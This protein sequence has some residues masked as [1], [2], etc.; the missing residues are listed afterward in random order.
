MNFISKEDFEG[1]NL[2]EFLSFRINITPVIIKIVYLLGVIGIVFFSLYSMF[3]RLHSFGQFIQQFIMG[4]L[5]II[6]GN[7]SWRIS[8]EL[9]MVIYN[10]LAELK[11]LNRS[12]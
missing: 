2:D 9:I 3:A 4:I 5:L 6:F 10:I 7:I 8:C 11:L 12:K 1:F